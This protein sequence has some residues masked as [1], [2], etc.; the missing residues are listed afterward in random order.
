MDY[1]LFRQMIEYNDDSLNL[2]EEESP[3]H[4]IGALQ[5]LWDAKI[6]TFVAAYDDYD[7]PY[8]GGMDG[9]VRC[10]EP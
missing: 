10:P 4:V 3:Q 9:P 6:P 7:L 8:N 2:S 1:D 5:C